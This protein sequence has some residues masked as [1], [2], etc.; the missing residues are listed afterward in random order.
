MNLEASKAAQTDANMRDDSIGSYT[1]EEFYEAARRFHGY[2]APGLMLGGYMMEEARKHLPE[3]TLF[4]AISETSWCLPDAVQMLSLCSIG[5]GWLKIKNLGVYALSLY[6]KYTGKGVRI[7][8][9]PSKLE[10]WPEIKSWFLKEKPKKDQDTE[11]LQAEIRMAGASLCLIESV[12]IKPE[13]MSHR[14]KGGITICPLCGDAYPGSFGAICRTCQ[15]E[16]PYLERESARQLKMEKLPDGLKSVPI[17]EAE[18]KKA[19]HDMTR[20]DPGDSKG[21]EFFKDHNFSAGD[22]CR[23][24]LI[25]KNHIY[26]DEG[27]I[28]LTNG[29]MKMKLP[30]HSGASWLGMELFR[31]E[32]RAKEKLISWRSRMVF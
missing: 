8:V 28:L 15:G 2:P 1:Y 7:R 30:K 20:I 29:Y 31:K 19:V 25:G 17:S 11:R 14:S 4:D 10:E 5:N 21:P 18:G 16:G 9:D 24:Q 3:G 13:V 27:D 12:Q 6:D 22:M 26:V 23:L 32:C